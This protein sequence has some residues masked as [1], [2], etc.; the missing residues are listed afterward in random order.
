MTR[1]GY[2]LIELVVAMIAASALV[3]SLAATIV[4]TAELLEVPPDNQTV[5]HDR[6]I[7]DRLAADL[8]YAS[9]IDESP[10][11]GFTVTRPDPASGTPQNVTYQAYLDGLTR[12]ADGGPAITYDSQAPSHV[13]QVDGFSAPTAA[14]AASNYVRLRSTST[15]VSSGTVASIDVGIPPGCKTGDL[16]LLCVSAKTPNSVTVSES[17]WQTLSIQGVDWL[18]LVSSYRIFDPSLPDQITIDVTPDA[19]VAVAMVALEHTDL[20]QPIDW[21]STGSGYALSWQPPSHPAPRESSGFWPGQLNVQ[22]F[23]ADGDPWHEGSL[24]LP[25]FTDA[26]QATAAEGDSFYENSVGIAIR[27]GPTATMST[28]PRVWHRTSGS[29]LQTGVRIEV[30]R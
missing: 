14:S 11:Y 8:R 25:S 5:W 16:L 15:A 21:S 10:T 7:A 19:A 17:G 24:G 2:S 9:R 28:T 12:R 13:F 30:D 29:W 27:S 22:I 18:R 26:A 3:S 20:S 1:R 4:I 6:A 23:A